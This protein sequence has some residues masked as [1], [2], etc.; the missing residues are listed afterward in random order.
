MLD[1]TVMFLLAMLLKIDYDF[2][3]IVVMVLVM[4]GNYVVSKRF[5]FQ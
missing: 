1:M 4:V 2:S 5:M 3:K